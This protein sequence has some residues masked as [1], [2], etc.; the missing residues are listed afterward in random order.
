MFELIRTTEGTISKA[1]YGKG[2]AFVSFLTVGFAIILLLL[3]YVNS[4][5]VWMT[6]AV[7]PFLAVIGAFVGFSILYFWTCLFMK[8]LRA[9]RHPQ[10]YVYIWLGVIFLIPVFQ[11]VLYEIVSLALPDAGLL[12]IS[13]PIAVALKALFL[14]TFLALVFLGFSKD[15]AE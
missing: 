11:L 7:A 5:M 13:A 12:A 15:K 4:Q 8:R 14:I 2:I 6:T 3:E 10:W 1:E 9:T